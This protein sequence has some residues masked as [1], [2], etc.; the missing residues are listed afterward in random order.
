MTKLVSTTPLKVNDELASKAFVKADV[1]WVK[2]NPFKVVVKFGPISWK[3]S[4]GNEFEY[5]CTPTMYN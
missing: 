5:C 3:D 2:G 1:E 4:S